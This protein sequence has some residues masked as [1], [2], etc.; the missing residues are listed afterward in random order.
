VS[1]TAAAAG[2]VAAAAA[3][4]SP[5]ASL[6]ASH[7]HGSSTSRRLQALLAEGSAL[8]VLSTEGSELPGGCCRAR[9]A[10]AAAF[11]PRVCL[12][13]SWPFQQGGQ[14]RRGTASWGLLR[15]QEWPQCITRAAWGA[16][17][18]HAAQ[19]PHLWRDLLQGSSYKLLCH[20][21]CLSFGGSQLPARSR[22][23]LLCLQAAGRL[24]S[25]M[26]RWTAAALAALMQRMS[27]RSRRSSARYTAQVRGLL[28]LWLQWVT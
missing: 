3:T 16:G 27:R 22:V 4:H 6:A 25:C 13:G 26:A 7:S 23:R 14:R 12:H 5:A 15:S 21:L 28:M 17:S 8:S 20:R 9:V 2:G 10:I 18:M 1:I 19:L 11:D 24:R